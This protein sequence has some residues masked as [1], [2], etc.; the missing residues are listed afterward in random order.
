MPDGTSE[1]AVF[2]CFVARATAAAGG[3][4][5]GALPALVACASW[6][7]LGAP[8][9]PGLA[10]VFA[11]HVRAWRDDDLDDDAILGRLRLLLQRSDA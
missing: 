4:R 8:A 11:A 3:R 1:R 10:G 5:K 7:Q 9:A 2:A 6:L